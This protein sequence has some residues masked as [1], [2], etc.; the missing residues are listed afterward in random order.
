VAVAKL[1]A[2]YS[3]CLVGSGGGPDGAQPIGLSDGGDGK[4]DG[5]VDTG[6]TGSGGSGSGTSGFNGTGIDFGNSTDGSGGSGGFII[7][8]AVGG[9]VNGG[10]DDV[11]PDPTANSGPGAGGDRVVST[12]IIVITLSNYTAPPRET[13]GGGTNGGNVDPPVPD[14]TDPTSLGDEMLF[15]INY[16]GAQCRSGW[17]MDPD[18]EVGAPECVFYDRAKQEFSSDGCRLVDP[19]FSNA[20]LRC[21]CLSCLYLH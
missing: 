12:P 21:S 9:G 5:E 8:G 16:E 11:A 6:S 3:N 10:R 15:T 20:L 4:S 14:P 17:W 7:P 18:T 1:S 2:K 19:D 13:G